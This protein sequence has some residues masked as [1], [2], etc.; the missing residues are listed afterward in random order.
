MAFQFFAPD[1]TTVLA[2]AEDI[3]LFQGLPVPTAFFS[4]Q[5]PDGATN[6][7]V[8]TDGFFEATM[9]PHGEYRFTLSA[10]GYDTMVVTVM[11]LYVE[12]EQVNE[13]DA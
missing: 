4:E 2:N 1:K 8:C 12:P 13:E 7:W 9:S 3:C 5:L 10:E 6:E 11:A